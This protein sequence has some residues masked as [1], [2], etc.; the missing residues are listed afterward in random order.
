M[1][2]KV[3]AV[4]GLARALTMTVVASVTVKDPVDGL[5]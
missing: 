2:R 1:P 5:A 3:A 4:V